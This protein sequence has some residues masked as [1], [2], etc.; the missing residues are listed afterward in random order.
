[1]TRPSPRFLLWASIAA[2]AAAFGALS[3]LRHD[4]FDTG[5]FDLGNMVQAVWSTAHGRPLRVT[6]L[7]GEQVSR[8]AAHFDPLLA[9]FAPLW[10]IWPSPHMLLA[11]QAILV[12]LGALPVYELARKHL[13][14]DAAGLGFALAYLVFPATEWMTLNEF[15][16]VALAC[17]FLLYAF[18]HLDEERLGAFALFA[19]LAGLTKEEIPLVVAGLG[20]WFALAHKRRLAGA[21][22]RVKRPRR[23][24]PTI[25]AG[26]RTAISAAV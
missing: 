7:H 8:L 17:P 5:R 25:A 19:A 20:V 1:M 16:P 10:W 23:A 13:G 6:N 9:A 26:R 12:A 24:A 4:A 3:S 21:A 2:Y 11:A 18:W 22:N 15:H 14:S